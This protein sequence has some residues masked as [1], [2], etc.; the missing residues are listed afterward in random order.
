MTFNERIRMF[1]TRRVI[2]ALCA[3][4]VCPVQAFGQAD[5]EF[6]P[7]PFKPFSEGA[8]DSG[9][10]K[11]PSRAQEAP[12]RPAP[13]TRDP[14]DDREIPLEPVEE[15]NDRIPARERDS[16]LGPQRER[17]DER[18][19]TIPGKT[20]SIAV[21]E[22]NPSMPRE[23]GFDWTLQPVSIADLEVGRTW[24]FQHG[25]PNLNDQE[26]AAYAELIQA[27]IDRRSI[28]PASLPTEVSMTGAWESA[29]YRFAEVRRQAWLN[30]TILIQPKPSG[31][32]DPFAPGAATPL[33]PTFRFE[34]LTAYS[35]QLDMQS[36]PAHFVARPVALY[37][38]FTPSGVVEMEAV[39]TLEGEQRLFRMQRGLLK[40][41]Q[42]TETLALVD[43]I[44]YVDPEDQTN[45]STAWPVEKRVQL[46]VLVKGWFVKLWGQRPLIFAEVV[47]MLTP[48]PY[49]QYIREHVQSR[50]RVSEDEAWLYYETLRQLQVTSPEVQAG[51]AAAEQQARMQILE[52][53]LRDTAATER[54]SLDQQ[55]RKGTIAK[56]DEDKKEGYDTRVT[57]LERQLGTR[58]ARHAKYLKDPASFPLFVDMFRNPDHWQGRLLTLRGHVRQVITHPGD[59]TLFQSQPLHEL[60]LYTQ[61]S[62][63]IPTVIV[64][65]SLPP[66]FPVGSDLIE[67]VTVTGCLFKMYA[68][69]SQEEG[70]LAPLVLAGRVE[71]NPAP[72]HVLALAKDGLIRSES[73][74]IARA[75][76]AD[77]LRVSESAVLFLGFIALLLAMTVWGRVQ[78]DRR[79]RRRVLHVV[80]ERP[81]FRQT[82][83]ELYSGPF[84]DSQIEPHRG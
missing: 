64:T 34:E 20:N 63:H 62:Q 54:A 2:A 15:L 49:D 41:L 12:K 80:D 78:R 38:M 30:K 77:P 8:T 75:K 65:P 42:G 82:S 36:N 18:D 53:E 59:S 1:L 69:R 25:K 24:P 19:G 74:L 84:A 40:N 60:W 83:Q 26:S 11:Q 47:R 13:K 67:S 43:A 32:S 39:H 16:T 45:P 57:R 5:E 61:D 21:G 81:D 55:L 46:P 27:A 7:L 58:L 37:G 17:A 68:Y 50:R 44:S 14:R 66:D 70:R 9:S 23:E 33:D 28:A 22:F 51:I 31:K 3:L 71:W 72:S 76:A 79:H 73:P 10:S 52:T 48:R 56:A 6:P 35:L 29:F 4:A